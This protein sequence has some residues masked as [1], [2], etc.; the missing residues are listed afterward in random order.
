MVDQRSDNVRE[1]IDKKS[2]LIALVNWQ[3]EQFSEVGHEREFNLLEMLIHG[4]ENEP[5]VEA[6]PV[7]NGCHRMKDVQSLNVQ[8]VNLKIMVDMRS[9]ALVVV[10]T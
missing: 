4:V 2:L 10:R 9:S 3:M 6:V 7:V 8:D 5:V 1:L